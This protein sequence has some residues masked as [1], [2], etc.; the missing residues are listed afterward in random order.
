[1]KLSEIEWVDLVLEPDLTRTRAEENKAHAELSGV[2]A[3]G[4]PIVLDA[5]E[6][7]RAA[8]QDLDADLTL[9]LDR[10]QFSYVRFPLTIRPGTQHDVRFLAFDVELTAEGN[11]KPVCWSLEPMKVT[12]EIKV[13]TGSKMSA[14]LKPELVEIGADLSRGEEVIHYQPLVTA[15]GI[16]LTTPAWELAATRGRQLLGV[17]ILH[18]V[19][20]APKRVASTATVEI[21]ADIF[22]RGFL[23]NSRVRHSSDSE[24]V[25]TVSLT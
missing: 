19:V 15:F 1:L 22:R 24:R 4:K 25:L 21:K 8:N 9:L 14:K 18:M 6:R 11:E 2:L 23:W 10:Y 13:T 12:Q 16:G 5:V 17:Q 3:V 20:K 7:A